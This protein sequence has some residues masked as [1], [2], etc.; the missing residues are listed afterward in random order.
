MADAKKTPHGRW[1]EE[2][3]AAEKELKKFHERGRR[4]VKR[5]LDDRDASESGSKWFNIFYANTNILESALYAQLPKP[6]VSRRFKDF[7]DDVGRV[8]GVM[9]ERSITQD[10]DDPTDTFDSTLRQ[11][12]QDRLVPGL[13]QAWLRLETET[14]DIEDVTPPTQ[15]GTED[16][17]GYKRIT[18]Q[19]VCVDYVFWED[20]L[21]S[22]CRVW[23]ERR[24]VA[25]RVYMDRESLVKRFGEEKGKAVSLDYKPLKVGSGEG[26]SAT[27]QDDTVQK[28]IVYEI[29][30]RKS[31][32]VFWVSKAFTQILDEVDDP[33]GLVNFEPCPTPMLANVSTSNTS[34]RPDYYMLQD[35]YDELNTINHRISKLV[36]A[37]KV[38]GVYD[39]ASKGV[40]RMLAEGFDN[41]MIPVDSWAAFAEKGGIK[42]QVDWLPLEEVVKALAQLTLAREAIKA[43]I[44]ELTGIAD[45]VRGASKASETLGAQE[46][47]AKFASV[48]IKKLQD[49]V[50]RFA[51]EI[52][53]IKAEIVVKH[54]DD[55]LILANSNI[56]KTP[57]ADIAGEALALL[58]SEEG[59]EWRI[60]VS[61][62][63]IAQAD[64][65]ME[66]KDRIEF[67]TAVSSYLE[68]AGAMFQTVPQSAPLLVGLLKWAV[69][70]FKNASEIEGM[71][72]KALDNLTKNPPQDK[73]DPEQQKMEME[74]KKMEAEMQA[75]QQKAEMEA[76]MEERK[77]QMEE[78]R[79]Q[80]E[81]RMEQ[82]KNDM[83]LAME[84]QM[85]QLKIWLEQMLA[86]V[87]LQTAQQQSAQKAQ[88]SEMDMALAGQ[89]HEQQMQQS[90]QQHQ[91]QLQTAKETSAV[92][93]QTKKA[94][95]KAAA[96]AKPKP[97]G[98]KNGR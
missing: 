75:D 62:D 96:T 80:M 50:A 83:E 13:A 66:K 98:G 35:Q 42:G 39:K 78:Q 21:W 45:I 37:C 31:R 73:P 10:L 44:Y 65:D 15:S 57:D 52:L 27:P 9:L 60:T 59:F 95:A 3:T 34:P 7:D 5:F 87:K 36:Q 67:L 33:L 89:E 69:A 12:V 24:W 38:V 14:E 82:Q 77:M 16:E 47:K 55:F 2:I 68:K 94:E 71:L 79:A 70:G 29:W 93:I 4:T 22:P 64:Y 53:R 40:S 20:F 23:A 86:S 74:Q 56:D 17:E 97:T 76:Q 46:I 88:E 90:Q 91:Q 43:Q 28:A 11:C 1:V 81:M 58:K 6:D 63:S 30:E 18:N 48:R 72:D 61:A 92:T 51:A 54:F 32:K 41:D 85:G 84:R 8:A 49:E 19:R 26:S 25:R